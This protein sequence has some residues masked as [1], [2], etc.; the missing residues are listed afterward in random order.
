MTFPS[1][2]YPGTEKQRTYTVTNDFLRSVYSTYLKLSRMG[3]PYKLPAP[4]IDKIPY[5]L[6]ETNY[7]QAEMTHIINNNTDMFI[8]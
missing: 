4:I 1:D 6:P 2:L 8:I 5:K 7:N 3:N